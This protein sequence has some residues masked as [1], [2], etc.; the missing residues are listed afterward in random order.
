[1]AKHVL[2][3]VDGSPLSHKALRHALREFPDASVT[4]LHVVDLFEPGYGA[5]SDVETTYEPL[6]GTEAWYERADEV[7]E[8]LLEEVRAIAEDYDRELE[9]VSEIG[10]PTR[11]VVDYAAEEDVDHVVIGAHG[12]PE[13]ARPI[14]GSVAETVARR[15]TVPV[16]IVR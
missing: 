12:R 15:A 3:P 9:T 6:M 4:A 13:E 10:D 16:T 11:I 7:S 8:E 2:V 5:A 14:Y 1:V